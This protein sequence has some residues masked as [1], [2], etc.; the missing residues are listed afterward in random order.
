[1]A[2]AKAVGMWRDQQIMGGNVSCDSRLFATEYPD[3]PVITSGAGHLMYAHGDA[4]HLALDDLMTS[5][6][7]IATY[8]LRQAEVC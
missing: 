7:F 3:M 8:L 1:M 5:I 2:A 6:A 4:E